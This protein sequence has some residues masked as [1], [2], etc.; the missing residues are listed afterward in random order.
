M[1]GDQVARFLGE[2]AVR[3]L[4]R[5]AQQRRVRRRALARLARGRRAQ[6]QLL[7]LTRGDEQAVGAGLDKVLGQNGSYNTVSALSLTLPDQ[8]PAGS[9]QGELTFT[10]LDK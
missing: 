6:Q 8:Q 5:T 9:Y 7:E 1:A 3:E 2:A 4:G 10:L